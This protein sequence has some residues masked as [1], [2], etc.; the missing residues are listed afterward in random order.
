MSYSIGCKALRIGA[1]GAAG[2]MGTLSESDTVKVY[3]NTLKFEQPDA[4][5]TPHYQENQMYPDVVVSDSAPGDFSFECHDVSKEN[6]VALLGGVADATTEKWSAQS[7]QFSV[8]KSIEIDTIFDET[9]QFPAVF[10]TGSLKWNA[11]R[12]EVMRISVKGMILKPADAETK[13]L[14][15]I[16]TV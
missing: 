10:L 13:P 15:K 4:T 14:I 9:W 8:E 7:D 6:L 5:L 2:T 3:K 12:T 11:N 16:P 1:I